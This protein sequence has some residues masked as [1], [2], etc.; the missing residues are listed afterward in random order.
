MKETKYQWELLEKETIPENYEKQLAPFG[1]SAEFAQYAWQIGLKTDEDLRIFFQPTLADLLDP[2]L[3]FD[4]EKAVNRIRQAIENQE[5]I[6]IYGDYD[7]DGITSTTVLKEAIETLGGDV[8]Y[9][10]PNRFKDG[11]GPNLRVYQEFINFGVGL[12]ITV[13]N[14]VAGHEAIAYAKNAGVDVVVTDHHELPEVLPDALAIVHPRHPSGAYPFGQLAGVGVSF[15]LACALLE[16]IPTELLELVA[17]GTIADL[18]PMTG[19]NRTLVQLGLAQMKYSDRVGLLAL[20]QVAKL[21]AEKVNE[22]DI[23]FQIAPRLNALG[24]LDD[25]SLGVELLSTFDFDEAKAMALKIDET[26]NQRKELVASLTQTALGQLTPDDSIAFAAG[27]NWHEGI[28]GIVAGKLLQ[29]KNAPAFVLTLNLETGIAK[30]SARSVDQFNVYEALRQHE[31]LFSAFGGH[32][33]AAGFSLP[34]ENLAAFK[35]AMIEAFSQVKRQ[36]VKEVV[37]VAFLEPIDKISKSFYQTL[38]LFG[39]FGTEHKRPFVQLNNQT[40]ENAKTI[41]DGTHLKFQL[42]NLSG[43][44]V[45]VLGFGKGDQVL[46]FTNNQPVDLLVNISLNEWNGTSKIQL[47]LVD[48]GISGEQIFDYRSQKNRLPHVTGKTRYL[49]FNAKN[50]KRLQLEDQ[51]VIDLNH[52]TPI[53]AADNLVMADCPADLQLAQE[54]LKKLAPT[55]IFLWLYSFEEAYLNGLP[56][57]TVFSQVFKFLQQQK[58]LDV[59]HKVPQVAQ[60]LKISEKNLILIIQVFFELNFV[61]IEDGL[62]NPVANPVAH[63]LTTSPSYQKYQQQ[64]KT[65][66]F[67]LY[68]PVAAIADWLK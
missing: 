23:G 8:V 7:A 66:E 57:R 44:P 67:L 25:A 11:Y 21:D 10:L 33:A 14:G 3:L 58:N 16:E 59:R 39:P 6:L 53:A 61:T 68:A 43:D 60:F 54:I 31:S 20:F 30:G 4:M 51:S 29:E 37:K 63:D 52:I 35:S 26:N 24:R 34:V 18:V 55:R 41:G 48:F 13:D 32:H 28:L 56:T 38:T 22:E 65:E 17:I 40:V 12:I 50:K 15:K 62:L 5:K 64:M 46:E 49:I 42:A 47:M 9:Y 45:D 2:Y 36:E 19:E 1:V 27:D